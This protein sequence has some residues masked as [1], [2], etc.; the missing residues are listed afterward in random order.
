M[1][2]FEN[3]GAEGKNTTPRPYMVMLTAIGYGYG[4]DFNVLYGY[5]KRTNSSRRPFL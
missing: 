5:I 2:V 1:S 4:G 3:E